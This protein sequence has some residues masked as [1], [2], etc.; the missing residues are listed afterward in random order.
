MDKYRLKY[1]ERNPDSSKIRNEDECLLLSE[2]HG[3]VQITRR[4]IN[5]PV[6]GMPPRDIEE[7][8]SDKTKY[9]WVIRNDS[10][11]MILEKSKA[12]E[13]LESRRA[14][15]TNLTGCE[16]AYCGGEV[17]FQSGKD[18]YISGASGRYTPR[19]S[20]ELDDICEVFKLLGFNILRCL[21][22]DSDLKMPHRILRG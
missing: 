6:S 11:P 4:Q 14:T 21:G 8:N 19:S 2:K 12:V 15:H 16:K 9:I 18:I 10:L 20:E 1:M 3:V 17:W 7:R 22:W 13:F 5:T